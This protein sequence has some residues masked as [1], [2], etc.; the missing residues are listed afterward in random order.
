V[1]HLTLL[2]RGNFPGGGSIEP[3]LAG[4]RD[5]VPRPKD[6]GEDPMSFLSSPPLSSARSLGAAGL[7][8]VLVGCGTN[9]TSHP[10][11]PANSPARPSGGPAAPPAGT[12]ALAV[13]AKAPPFTLKD[14]KGAERTLDDFLKK[15]EVALVFFRSARW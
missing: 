10:G 4:R 14:Q 9:P 12:G 2:I 1:A 3:T 13:G 11:P 8:A 7:L 5:A 6:P 15:G